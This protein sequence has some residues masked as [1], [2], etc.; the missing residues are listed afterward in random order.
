MSPWNYPFQLSLTPLVGALA[1]GNCAIVKPS[2]Y[3]PATAKI[4]AD[5]LQKCF[6]SSYVSVVLGGRAE[7]TDLLEQKFDYIF[8]TGGT[9]AA[10]LL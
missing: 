9:E 3:A 2:D 8:F 4:I 5:L 7:N 10:K 6:A 1:A